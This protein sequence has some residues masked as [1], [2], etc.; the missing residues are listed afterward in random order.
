MADGPP[1]AQTEKEPADWKDRFFPL[2]P[3]LAVLAAYLPTYLSLSRT[4][5]RSDD[6]AFGPIIGV[7]TAALL[8][9]YRAAL[10]APGSG[11]ARLNG[12]ILLGIGLLSHIAGSALAV[13]ELDVASQIPVVAGLA[14]LLGGHEALRRLW[15]PIAFL[16]FMIPL[17]G[18]L[19]VQLTGSLKEWVAY[20]ADA[21]LYA[22]GFPVARLGNVI[23]I[24]QYQLFIADACSGMHSLMA[25]SAL[26]L[27]FVHLTER[28]SRWRDALLVAAILPI[29]LLANLVRV[30]LLLLFTY[31]FGDQFTH[32]AHGAAGL[33]VFVV[34]IVLLYGMHRLLAHGTGRKAMPRARVLPTRPG[35]SARCLRLAT[36]LA[37]AG[38]AAQMLHPATSP[39]PPLGLAGFAPKEFGEW[40][41]VAEDVSTL[42][43]VKTDD[44]L[45]DPY[46]RQ[47]A[48]IYAS[49]A[50]ESIML[51]IAY[52]PN[53][54]SDR[55]HVHRP[56]YC[57]GAQGFNVTEPE[58]GSLS[59]PGGRMPVRRLRT[60]LGQRK[61]PVTYW[62]T[63]N[64]LAV[65]PGWPRKLAQL[66]SGIQGTVPD[67]L[68][69]R[70]SSIDADSQR[71][72]AVQERFVRDWISSL[73]VAQRRSL[74][75]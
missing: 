50:G 47:L 31:R 74:G 20:L 65:L 28:S 37:L 15:F 67:G 1:S 42:S 6:Y 32:A 5:W 68:L 66:R 22:C 27:L 48:V 57:Y 59:I 53:Q 18:V 21:L 33:L 38:L 12:A 51:S 43:V 44:E 64:D 45:P 35:E 7:V 39:R 58:N 62:M 73:D 72:F 54:L 9:Q 63:V 36:V 52:A 3:W 34:E 75:N 61:E 25:M 40:R 26:G 49:S 60:E 17:P 16:A 4:L 14:L 24:G 55:L 11:H 30:L 56:E 71:A 46:A 10:R 13:P 69:V 2:L 41:R 29:A 23:S 8:W 70:V 19:V